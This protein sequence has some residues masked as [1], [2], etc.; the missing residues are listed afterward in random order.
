MNYNELQHTGKKGMRW[1][2]RSGPSKAA[3][4]RA[5]RKR[6]PVEEKLYRDAVDAHK[7]ALSKNISDKKYN[8]IVAIENLAWNQRAS[9]AS[10]AHKKTGGEKVAVAL[11]TIGMVGVTSLAFAKLIK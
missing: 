5:A 8:E 3:N 7:K 4:I 9:T 6:L 10:L 11:T 1:G 2:H